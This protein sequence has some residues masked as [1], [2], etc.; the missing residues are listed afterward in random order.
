MLQERAHLFF[1]KT[2]EIDD[3]SI[4]HN[5]IGGGM[6]SVLASSAVDL[7]FEPRSGK[8]KEYIIGIY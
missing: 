8:A 4:L 1:F 6:I 5:C 3:I 7:R 2:F